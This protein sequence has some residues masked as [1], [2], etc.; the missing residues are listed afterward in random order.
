[1]RYVLIVTFVLAA[2]ATA[3][4]DPFY[5]RY[6]P[7]EGRF[8]EQEGW[9]RYWDDPEDK[10][11]RSAENGVFRLDT[12]GS[13]SIFDLYEAVSPAFALGASEELRVRWEMETLQTDQWSHRSDVCVAIA[14]ESHAFVQLFLAPSY[15]SEDE[16]PGGEP[17]R[18]YWFE[19]AARH[20]YEFITLDMETYALYV[21]G[22]LAF[23]GVFHDYA[24][25]EVP[26]VA[27]GDAIIGRTSLSEWEYV[28]VEVLPE[29][30]TRVLVLASGIAL[31]ASYR[32]HGIRGQHM[33]FLDGCR[34]AGYSAGMARL[35]CS[36]VLRPRPP[37]RMPK[38]TEK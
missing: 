34:A 22:A 35:A 38:A 19:P 9:G 7:D 8:P 2:A 16:L 14:N 5:L 18:L 20:A 26:R 30:A 25:R 1:M 24:W 33:Y 13:Y 10:L 11:V 29:P 21:D 15:V 32:S 6:D 31:I 37:G 28:E 3:A 17:E 12:R 23:G 36:R 4:A 27:F